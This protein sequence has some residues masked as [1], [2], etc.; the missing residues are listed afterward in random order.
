ML[1]ML[2][3]SKSFLKEFWLMFIISWNIFTRTRWK[4]KIFEFLKFFKFCYRRLK[5]YVGKSSKIL[6]NYFLIKIFCSVTLSYTKNP[7]LLWTMVQNFSSIT[8]QFH[9]LKY[10]LNWIAES[11]LY[12]SL[13]CYIVLYILQIERFF[14]TSFISQN[15][16]RGNS[17]VLFFNFF[18]DTIH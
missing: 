8:F 13:S 17:I 18:L 6:Q 10:I 5:F 3:I 7:I 9:E 2:T 11:H 15:V 16:G 12:D 1:L 4:L 14:K